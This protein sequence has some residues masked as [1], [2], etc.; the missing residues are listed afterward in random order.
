MLD[1]LE[2][3]TLLAQYA[4]VSDDLEEQTLLAQGVMAG[5]GGGEQEQD[6][7]Q[8]TDCASLVVGHDGG[9]QVVELPS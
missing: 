7:V 2:N 6:Q 4:A 1:D 3:Q 9:E 5:H 8:A